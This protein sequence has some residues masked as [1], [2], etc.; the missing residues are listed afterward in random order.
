MHS[1]SLSPGEK[2]VPCA[3]PAP[4]T[5]PPA[6]RWAEKERWKALPGNRYTPEELDHL[7]SPETFSIAFRRP[8]PMIVI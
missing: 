4:S 6:E 8:S 5:E 7:A 2:A 3:P 1:D